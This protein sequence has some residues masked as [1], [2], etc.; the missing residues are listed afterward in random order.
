MEL[1]SHFLGKDQFSGRETSS[2]GFGD[3][4]LPFLIPC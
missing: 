1:Y 3:G 4:V 2:S